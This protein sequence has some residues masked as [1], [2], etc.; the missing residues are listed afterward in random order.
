MAEQHLGLGFHIKLAQLLTY[1]RYR[2]I[3][4][5]QIKTIGADLLLQS[6]PVDTDL[7]GVVNHIIE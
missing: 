6:R 2:L 4:F 1:T 3:Q 7:T 5:N